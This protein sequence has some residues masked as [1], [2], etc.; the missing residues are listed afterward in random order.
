MEDLEL[1]VTNPIRSRVGDTAAMSTPRSPIDRRS[2][3]TKFT[4][5]IP[6]SYSK[7]S[8]AQR[9]SDIKTKLSRWSSTEFKVYGLIFAAVVPVM[10]WVPI[11]LSMC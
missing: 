4:V 9:S 8:S 2:G 11:R 10:I 5:N 3:P 7:S 6:E 1:P